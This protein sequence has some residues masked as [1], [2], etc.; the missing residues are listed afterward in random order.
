MA[1]V[2]NQKQRLDR[3]FLDVSGV[4]P[5]KN[6]H[7]I[8]LYGLESGLG[9]FNPI[10]VENLNKIPEPKDYEDKAALAKME[11]AEQKR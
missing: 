4:S 5:I 11:K 8:D 6:R 9:H 7:P 3:D 1:T 10:M 2:F